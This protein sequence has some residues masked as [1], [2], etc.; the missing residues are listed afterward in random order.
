LRLVLMGKKA[1]R[2]AEGK[3][4]EIVSK[5]VESALEMPEAAS[6]ALK[7]RKRRQPEG[8]AASEEGAAVASEVV[9]AVDGNDARGHTGKRKRRRKRKDASE[10]GEGD[11]SG[12]AAVHEEPPE[13]EAGDEAT[14]RTVYVE[15]IPFDANETQ[16]RDV[17]KCCGTIMDVRMPT[18]HDS[19][20]S[21]GYAH[22]EFGTSRSAELA[23]TKD[24]ATMG[25]RYL[26][27]QRSNSRRG[28]KRAVPDKPRPP[29][30]RTLHVK[31]VPYE[32]AEEDIKAVFSPLGEVSS[33]R[34]PRWGH[35]GNTKGV[36]YVEFASGEATDSV[37]AKA[38][39][40]MNGR[41]L[42]L[43]WELGRPKR[44]FKLADGRN[45]GKVVRAERREKDVARL[46]ASKFKKGGKKGTRGG[47]DE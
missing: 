21:R 42:E 4:V 38:P 8:E 20:R 17:F 22:I 24:G 15:G 41:T 34:I 1:T 40:Q 6:K 10:A 31:N 14:S 18:F 12:A 3:K 13:A 37:V 46:A 33:I 11:G 35:T 43:D 23:L 7:A 27:V 5:E 39:I 16:L 30:C 29:K 45:F 32:A 19:G 44:S 36:A 9:D 2:E 26:S 25:S 28:N 47:A